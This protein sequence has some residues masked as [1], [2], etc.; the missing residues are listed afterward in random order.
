MLPRL[1]TL[2]RKHGPSGFAQSRDERA[3][4]EV[5]RLTSDNAAQQT[6]LD[7]LDRAARTWMN[8]IAGKEIALMRDPATRDQARALEVAGAGK[9]SMDAVRAKVA[10]IAKVEADLLVVRAAQQDTAFSAT[11]TVAWTG[12]LAAFL[13][14]GAMCWA[15]GRGIA[16]PIVRMTELMARLA[17]GDK[18]V[19]VTG[20]DRRDEIGAM[21][22]AVEVFKRNAI[23][24][25]RLAAEQ[26]REHAV[27]EQRASTVGKLIQAFEAAVVQM[28]SRRV[29]REHA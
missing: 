24:A 10:E 18:G 26:A 3:F 4:A 13:I 8:D 25:D 27:K 7:H 5:R 20:T 2:P 12:A 29:R 28:D 23:E 19:Q 16:K 9:Q 14:A 1:S 17:S 11:Y 15:L 21:A 22:Q 6:R